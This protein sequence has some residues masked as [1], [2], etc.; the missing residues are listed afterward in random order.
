MSSCVT[1]PGIPLKPCCDKFY[2]LMYSGDPLASRVE[3]LLASEFTHITPVWIPKKTLVLA[4][5][6]PS[7]LMEAFDSCRELFVAQDYTGDHTGIAESLVNTLSDSEDHMSTE[8]TTDN[9]NSDVP[10]QSSMFIYVCC[11]IWYISHVCYNVT[12]T[13]GRLASSS[14]TLFHTQ[15]STRGM[16]ENLLSLPKI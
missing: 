10:G 13:P 9:D 5:G 1:L 7:A 3:P 16:K 12:A 15:Y 6:L 11:C 14:V 2:N 4:Q 8:S